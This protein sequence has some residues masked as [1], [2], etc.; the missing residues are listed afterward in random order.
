MGKTVGIAVG[1]FVLEPGL[2]GEADQT[3]GVA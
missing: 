2:T 1:C 3:A